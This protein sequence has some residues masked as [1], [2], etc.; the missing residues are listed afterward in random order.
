MLGCDLA[1]QVNRLSARTVATLSKPGRH[2]DGNGLYLVVDRSG[3]R[4]WVFLFR[5]AGTL[6]EMGLGGVAAV[7]LADARSKAA[8]A[9]KHLDAGRNPIAARKEAEAAAQTPRDFGAFVDALVPEIV[10]GFR[11]AKHREQWKNTLNQHAASLRPLRLD[12]IG[13]S[14][15]LDVLKPIWLVIPETASRLRGRIEFV[16]AAATVKGFRSGENPA[17]WRNHLD[18]LLPKRPKLARGH[19]AAMPYKDVPAFVSS[20]RDREATA[21]RA[22]E[23]LI[24]TASRTGEAIGMKWP[25]VDEQTGIWTVPAERMKN[26]KPHRV[27]LCAQALVIL[28]KQAE[29][30]EGD[31]VFAGAKRG[32]PLSSHAVL[33]LVRRMKAE[34]F[35]PHGFRSSFRDWADECTSFPSQIIEMSLSHRS[36]DDTELAYRRSD[37]LEKRRKLMTAWG[38]FIDAPKAKPNNVTPIRAKV[39]G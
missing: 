17:R 3:A 38:S 19:H 31:Y 13:T 15:I 10:T 24:V 20:L 30:K 29:V 33:M 18:K 34:Q 26:G 14:H 9:R 1:R 37:A 32:R 6:K 5:M 4:R 2:A 35:T 36:G 27:P 22:L 39:A 23:Y 12:E 21:A 28:K 11:S 25:E 8:E 16:L 7:S